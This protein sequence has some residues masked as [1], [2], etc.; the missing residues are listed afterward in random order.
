[1]F[2]M[3]PDKVDHMPTTRL[4]TYANVIVDYQAQNNNPYRIQVTAGGNL[5]N[6]P[7]GLTMWTADITTSNSIGTVSSAHNKQNTC[8]LT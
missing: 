4:A 8:T 6:Y 3:T 5:I 7:G 1:M 2:V